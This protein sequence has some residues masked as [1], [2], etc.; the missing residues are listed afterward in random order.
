[1]NFTWDFWA[2]DACH[3]CNG[4]K[5]LVNSGAE[6]CMLQRYACLSLKW[7]SRALEY[8]CLSYNLHSIMIIK[9]IQIQ[10][11]WLYKI[12]WSKLQI[13]KLQI[14]NNSWADIR[15]EKFLSILYLRRNN[16][17]VSRKE[18]EIET[19]LDKLRKIIDDCNNY[20]HLEFEII[21]NLMTCRSFVVQYV[22]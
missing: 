15:R 8:V 1:M 18:W 14:K 10:E 19:C 11:Y 6:I 22:S 7:W 13:T 9:F 16:I 2:S 12:R 3:T 17:Q 5:W 4:G 21:I 20:E